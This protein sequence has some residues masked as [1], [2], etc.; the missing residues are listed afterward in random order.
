M[1]DNLDSITTNL[2]LLNADPKHRVNIWLRPYAFD[3]VIQW[4]RMNR[5]PLAGD[6]TWE[7]VNEHTVMIPINYGGYKIAFIKSEIQ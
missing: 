2:I 3:S 1:W 7:G 5:I 4:V 6:L